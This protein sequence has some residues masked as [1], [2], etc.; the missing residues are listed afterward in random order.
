MP[1]S[2]ALAE[3]LARATV[4]VYEDAELALLQLLAR[5]L[6][7]GL[8]RPLWAVERLARVQTVRTDA[9]RVVAALQRAAGVSIAEAVGVAYARGLA[10]ALVDLERAR[11][12][13]A[14]VL[15]GGRATDALIGETVQ[16]V[17]ATHAG[18]LRATVDIYRQVVAEVAGRV[19]LGVETRRQ[20][21]Q[22]ALDRLASRGITGFRDQRGRRW[23]VVSYAEMA[24]RTATGR[25]AIEGHLD[26][27]SA[28][29]LDLVI[30]SDAPQECPLC[31]PWESKVLA[32]TGAAG[33]VQ[34]ANVLTGRPMRVHV[35]GTVATARA[36]GLFHPSCRHSLSAFLPGLTHPTTGTADPQGDRDR[37]QLRYLERGVRQWRRR[38]ALA[39]D[40]Q[41][42]A[43]ARA[44]ARAWQ[45]RIRSHVASTSAKRQPQRERIGTAR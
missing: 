10:A 22:A 36:A 21:A 1:V 34:V 29:G 8:E 37:Q 16:A 28:A 41:A 7:Q 26:R 11:V 4:R 2:P 35:A 13:A 24:M 17:T 25:A 14:Q 9:Q 23:D 30:V 45:A 40:D 5:R 44:R 32:R 3:G 38:E 12:R 19:L 43:R 27:L 20:A 6:G 31:R 39:L 33:V 15:P 42:A 18:I